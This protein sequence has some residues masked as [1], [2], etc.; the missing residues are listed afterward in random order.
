MCRESVLSVALILMASMAGNVWA[1]TLASNPNPPNQMNCVD[2]NVY[3]DWTPGICAALHDV[4][5]G[6]NF[7]D[8]NDPSPSSAAYRGRQASTTYD[9]GPLL[10]NTT[11]FWRIIEVNDMHPE[12]P[13]IGPLW[14]FT[15][16]VIAYPT[17]PVKATASSFTA[18]SGPEKTI[19]ASGLDASDQHSINPADMWLSSPKPPQWVLYEFDTVYSLDQMWVWNYNT[20][21]E[22]VVG[23]GAKDVTIQYSED[24]V[25]W[26]TLMGVPEFA[27]ARGESTYVYNTTVNFA[28]AQA[29]YVKLTIISNWANAAT[30]CGLSEVR[31]F[32][33]R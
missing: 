8:V 6:T 7:S 13:W 29:K 19:D 25:I 11:Y 2:P 22:P 4:Y 9:P 18:G 16:E 10:P 26:M 12:S 24:G 1:I 33:L 32:A 5:F 31:F 14:S 3:L 30:R 15:T 23:F 27:Q 28:G 21:T 17:A 20:G